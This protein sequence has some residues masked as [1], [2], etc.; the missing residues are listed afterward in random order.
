MSVS[1]FVPGIPQPKGSA[2]SYV[3][4]RGR[5]STIQDNRDKLMPWQAAVGWGAK[6]AGVRP[7][8]GAVWLDA[9][10]VF[11]RPKGH[12]GKRGLLPSAPKHHTQKPDRDKL[13][14]AVLDALTGVAYVDDSQVVAGIALKRWADEGEPAGVHITIA[15]E[16]EI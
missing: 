15:L 11:T 2:R 12:Y 8:R 14:R 10:F 16:E 6:A 4:K 13:E 5:L 7:V 9:I 3:S 1:F